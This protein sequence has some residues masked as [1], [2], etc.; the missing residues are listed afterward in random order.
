[1][2]TVEEITLLRAF[3]TS[4]RRT[5]IL[6]LMNE[7]GMMQDEELIAQCMSMVKKLDNVT[8]TDFAGVDFTVYDDE[9]ADHE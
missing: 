7:M 8:D 9:E 5:A 1:M 2:F 6:S 3:D 4:T